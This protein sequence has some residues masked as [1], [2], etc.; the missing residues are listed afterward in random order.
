MPVYSNPFPGIR[1]FE[2]NEAK[3]FFGREARIDELISILLKKRFVAVLGSSGC[4]KS[5]LIKAGVIPT[6]F[7]R[8]AEKEKS[9]WRQFFFRPGDDPIQNLANSMLE[10]YAESGIDTELTTK[11][12]ENIFRNNKEGLVEI[13]KKHDNDQNFSR[14]IYVD[15]FEEIFRYQN[16]SDGNL[17]FSDADLFVSH[18]LYAANQSEVP[19]YVVIS[20]RSDFL[21]DCTEFKGLPEFINNGSYLVPRMN[22]DEKKR[23]ITGPIESFGATITERLV[24]VVIKDAGNDPDQLLVLQHAMMRTWDY[25][26]SQKTKDTAIDVS[27]YEAI[28]TI[29]KAL[30][31]H[32]EQIY[33]ELYN[34]S[35]KQVAEKLFKSLINIRDGRV[36]RRPTSLHEICILTASPSENVEKVIDK[37]RET[38]NSFLMPPVKEILESDTMIDISHESIMTIWERAKSWANEEIK[39][40]ELYSRLSRSAELYQEGKTGLWINPDLELALNWKKENNPNPTWAERYDPAFDRAMT[41]LDY[42]KKDYDIQIEKKEQQQKRKLRFTRFFTFFLGIATLISILFLMVALDLQFKA[43]KSAI[44][45]VEKQKE[46]VKAKVYAQQKS[47]EAIAHKKIAE[48]QQKIAVQQ[49]MISE[50][51]KKFA[52]KQQN[53]AIYEKKEANIARNE[54]FK[55]KKEAEIAKD[56]AEQQREKADSMKDI[57][58]NQKLISEKLKNLAVAK[59]I[60]IQSTEIA[61]TSEGKS[62]LAGLLALEAYKL[63]TKNGDFKNEPDIITALLNSSDCKTVNYDHEDKVNSVTAIS[64]DIIASSSADNTIRIHNLKT[65]KSEIIKTDADIEFIKYIPAL[66]MIV[67]FSKKKEILQWDIES[68]KQVSEKMIVPTTNR[69]VVD[70]SNN[71]KIAFAMSDSLVCVSDFIGKSADSVKIVTKKITA[72]RFN[73]EGNNIAIADTDKKIKLYSLAKTAAQKIKEVDIMETANQLA[74]SKSGKMIAYA[75]KNNTVILWN[76]QNDK[77]LSTS[78]RHNSK[79]NKLVFNPVTTQLASCSYDG[80]IKICDYSHIKKEPVSIPD[81]DDWVYDLAFSKSGNKIISVGNDKTVRSWVINPDSLAKLIKVKRKLTDE[82]RNKY[83]GLGSK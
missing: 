46:A 27:H 55:R 12:I 44:T 54:A 52:I 37:F 4:G 25:W 7:N 65:G 48:Q 40:V 15:Q 51:Q 5:S 72:I 47:K 39:S 19:V 26:E 60:A 75:L 10:S 13:I 59:S 20:L 32:G 78:I 58:I 74:F 34:D 42:C 73:T 36:T 9:V 31:Y 24:D 79:V 17:S 35:L 81:H 63:N 67:G 23:A 45:A 83:L 49:R 28:G 64:D 43:E 2:P 69:K 14:L 62:E 53:I 80:T 1:S 30:S 38:G 21:G 66:K 11:Q 71:G 41:Y 56:I 68:K 33:N 8:D 77:K 57:A 3:L 61:K 22:L 70:I 6:L 82:E 29:R 50:E 16:D 76:T 18:L